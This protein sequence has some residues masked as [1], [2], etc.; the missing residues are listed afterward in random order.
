MRKLKLLPK[1]P[2]YRAI[3]Y[4]NLHNPFE[5]V[6]HKNNKKKIKRNPHKSYGYLVQPRLG[7]WLIDFLR[8]QLKYS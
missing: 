3:D 4:T 1:E 6:T 8:G 2:K 5:V 7:Q